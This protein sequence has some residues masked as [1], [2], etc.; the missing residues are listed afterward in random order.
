MRHTSGSRQ[1]RRRIPARGS[2]IG[3]RLSDL[4]VYVLD[5]HGEPVPVGVVGEI[6]IGGAGSSA[7][8]LNKP[9]LTAER[10]LPDPFS[11]E[12]GARM[13]RTGDLGRYLPDGNLVFLGRNDE[14][15]K[16]RGYRIELGEIEAQLRA[17]EGVREAVVL[18]REEAGEKRLV[19]YVVGEEWLLAEELRRQLQQKLPEYMVPAAYVQ[20]E[21]L[22]L[23][24]NGK[25]D[26]R[27]L[28]APQS[29]AY[30]RGVYEEPQ[31]EIEQALAGIWQEVL[32]VDRIGRHDNFFELGGHSL[33]VI[34]LIERMRQRLLH[35]EVREVFTA[36]TLAQLAM[37]V[38]VQ[39]TIAI[40][41]N[42]I[43]EDTTSI[44]P[45]M[46]PLVSLSQ[47]EIDRVV[48]TVVGGVRNLQDIYPLAPLQEG[49]LFH[50]L[51]D[52]QGDTYLLPLLQSF[53]SRERLERYLSAL[54]VVIDRHD[55]LRTAI[56]WEGLREPVQV[57]WREAQLHVQEVHLEGED[58]A[59]QLRC[60]F[61]PR[62]YRM[63][64]HRA[65]LMEVFIAQ[66]VTNDRWLLLQL[67][68]HI[69]SDHTTME[70]V[71]QE[72][73]AHVL[74]ESAR[75][76]APIPFRNFVAQ[77]RLGVSAAEHEEF[78]R[79]MLGGVEE[80]TAP[81][82][83]LEVHGDGS[84]IREARMPVKEELDG[85]YESARDRRR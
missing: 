46:L 1:P 10:F 35:A 34:R 51:M 18:A 79:R 78:F 39:G 5:R 76:S 13:Y 49:I 40:P 20:L 62:R 59:G 83:L 50:Y 27:A 25:L 23:T 69:V 33:L 36:P 9:E 31:G 57:V 21:G 2:P 12:A 47:G 52:Q 15:V 29:D 63:E 38:Q 54:Q 84:R 41:P 85:G 7:R 30:G 24:P 74:G 8:Y 80:P 64:L 70:I 45:Q 68:H 43:T 71:L 48:E 44:T 6:Y 28:P 77:S 32:Q 82:G 53:D 22:P 61:D 14:Q 55:I 56:V 17:L 58:V 26:R 42:T 66:D 16:I 60:R 11:P 81:F 75:L 3:S 65:P 37:M 72:I 73:Q 4:R 67:S 19:A